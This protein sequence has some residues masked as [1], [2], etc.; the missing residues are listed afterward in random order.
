MWITILFGLLLIPKAYIVFESD[1]NL[2]IFLNPLLLLAL[3][4][5]TLLPAK[6]ET[7]NPIGNEIIVGLH[8]ELKLES[9]I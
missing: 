3:L 5:V 9:N 8:D 4:I 7:Y 1:I 6:P 2:G